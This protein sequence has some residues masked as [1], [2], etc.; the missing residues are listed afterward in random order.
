M[1]FK[2]LIASASFCILKSLYIS[3]GSDNW[4]IHSSALGY[5]VDTT[6]ITPTASQYSAIRETIS[7]LDEQLA[8]KIV[9]VNSY[10]SG[11]LEL[12]ITYACK[13]PIEYGR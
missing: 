12:C 3:P 4:S 8:L 5:Q 1:Y 11:F 2:F 13:I 7:K 10:L 9:E 6:T